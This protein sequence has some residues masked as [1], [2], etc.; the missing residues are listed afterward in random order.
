MRISDILR[1]KGHQVA[2]VTPDTTVR[3]LLAVLAERNIG[4]VVV[5]AGGEIAGIA[6]E[7]DVVRRLHERGTGLLADPVDSIMTREVRTCAPSDHIEWLRPV[8]TEHRIRHV[9]VV[10]EGRLVGIV[11]IGDVVKSA[12]DQLETERE[13]LVAYVQS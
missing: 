9:P 1:R 6:S 8:M 3:D 7:R 2:T 12:I 13:A 5:V 10:D 4:A 11:S